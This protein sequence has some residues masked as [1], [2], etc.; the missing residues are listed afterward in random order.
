VFTHVPREELAGLLGRV[1][2]WLRPGGVLLAAFGVED[3]PGGVE[4]DWLGVPMYFSH[5]SA[6]VNRRLVAEA[7][8]AV[9]V[10]EVLEEPADRHG[11]RF[12]WVL[13]RRPG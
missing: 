7:G 9:E 3:D 4:P 2:G 10:A 1:A 6:R 5:W 13:A 8:L 11:A 12:L